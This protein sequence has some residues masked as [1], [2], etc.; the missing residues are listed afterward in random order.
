MSTNVTGLAGAD[1]TA[2]DFEPNVTG[3]IDTT[4]HRNVSPNHYAWLYIVGA[5]GLLWVT[6]ASFK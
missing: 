3:S 4:W 5:L 2:V 6:G 1:T